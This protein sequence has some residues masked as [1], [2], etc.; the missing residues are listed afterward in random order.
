MLRLLRKIVL[1]SSFFAIYTFAN[2]AMISQ[3]SSA[4]FSSFFSFFL[5]IVALGAILS[6]GLSLAQKRPEFLAYGC[7]GFFLSVFIVGLILTI[8]EFVKAYSIFLLSEAFF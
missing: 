8:I 5:P 4:F 6:V 3:M 2:D 1:L 7:G